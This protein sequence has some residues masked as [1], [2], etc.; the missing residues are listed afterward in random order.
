MFSTFWVLSN[1]VIVGERILNICKG[2]LPTLAF[3]VVLSYE[4][5]N[6]LFADYLDPSRFSKFKIT[7]THYY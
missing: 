6:I 7:E 4:L 3:H 5:P 1:E 2:R